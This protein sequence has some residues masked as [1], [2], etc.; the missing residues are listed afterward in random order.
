MD[1]ILHEPAPLLARPDADDALR[2][3]LARAMSDRLDRRPQTALALARA[4]QGVQ[5]GMRLPTT[6]IDVLDASVE[7]VAED[8]A[9][10]ELTS[11]RPIT[12]IHQ[13]P[14][15]V[16]DATL[17]KAISTPSPARPVYCSPQETAVAIP[18]GDRP[19]AESPRDQ[20]AALPESD[21]PAAPARRGLLVGVVVGAAAV[22]AL[23][24]GLAMMGD[25]AG[26]QREVDRIDT[27][28]DRAPVEDTVEVPAP[29]S[30]T[31][32]RGELQGRTAVFTWS[33]PDHQ[34]GDTYRWT[35][36]GDGSEPSYTLAE[37]ARAQVDVPPGRRACI[38][39]TTVRSGQQSDPSPLGCAEA[40]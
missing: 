35:L 38:V 23:L 8:P 22:A 13:T 6:R 24:G 16:E 28:T 12:V 33:A 3:V 21:P 10:D 15:E 29:A 37:T 7:R 11:V 2:A 36:A 20:A 25:D 4:L 19:P 31:D 26:D 39:V 40:P 27:G 34:E 14:S 17:A 1:R 9:H 5:V 18:S 32:L 30:P